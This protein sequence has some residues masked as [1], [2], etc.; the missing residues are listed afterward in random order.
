MLDLWHARWREGRIGFHEGKPNEY[1]VRFGDRLRG[2]VLVPLCGKT[3]D[4]AYLASR[5]HDV[6]GIEL[7]EDAVRAFFAEHALA[8]AVERRG[9][10]AIYRAGT[11]A[12]ACGDVLAA[13][14][15][16]IGAFDSIYD[17][18]ALIALPAEARARY[19]A[20]LRAL[21]APG[22]PMLVITLEYPQ[23]AMAGPPFA[24]LESEL[25]A[26]YPGA[27][28]ELLAEGPDPRGRPMQERCFATRL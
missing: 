14:A 28:F 8:P 19:A 17:R 26:L 4:L 7:V 13:G 2:R 10:F 1:L 11:I 21:A 25:G 22:T 27:A 18:A 3:E 20:H 16:V 15:D 24:V 6:F 12:I 9:D 23:D 5:S